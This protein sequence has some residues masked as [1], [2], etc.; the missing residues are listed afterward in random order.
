MLTP[1]AAAMASVRPPARPSWAN[2]RSAADRIFARV[3]APRAWPGA[4]CFSP[5]HNLTNQIV[6]LERRHC[7]VPARVPGARI[8]SIRSTQAA[9]PARESGAS[10]C[11]ML[12]G[13]QSP[14]NPRGDSIRSCCELR[15]LAF[16]ERGL[17]QSAARRQPNERGSREPPS[18]QT[19]W[20]PMALKSAGATAAGHAASWEPPL[21]RDE[22]RESPKHQFSG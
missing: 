10:P 8:A 12:A 2:A 4:P 17:S 13:H 20:A 5:L 3:S 18:I 15:Q 19:R 16:R 22:L 9:K 11:C 21:R 14:A 1:A 7:Q 6:N